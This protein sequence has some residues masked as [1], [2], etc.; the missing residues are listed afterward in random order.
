M[1]PLSQFI[2]VFTIKYL[3]KIRHPCGIWWDDLCHG[4][5]KGEILVQHYSVLHYLSWAVSKLLVTLWHFLD[6]SQNKMVFIIFLQRI[7]G[8]SCLMMYM[9]HVLYTVTLWIL[10][11]FGDVTQINLN[12]KSMWAEYVRDSIMPLFLLIFKWPILAFK[13]FSLGKSSYF[14]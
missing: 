4:I 11:V 7:Q 10:P 8:L 1:T 3:W 14:S 12:L 13:N 5:G 9:Y 2:V 6:L